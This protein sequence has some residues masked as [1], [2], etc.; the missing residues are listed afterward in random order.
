MRIFTPIRAILLLAALL[1]AHPLAAQTLRIGVRAAML[2]PDP[3][4]SFNPDRG[5]TLQVYE[6]LLLQDANLQPTPGLAVAWKMRDPTTWE[7]KLRPGVLFQDGTPL[8]PADVLFSMN[9]IREVDVTQNYRANLRE[10]TGAEAEGSD[11][12]VIH[13][14]N[15][16]PTLPFDLATFPIVSARA[17]EHAA[18]EDFNGGRAAVGTGPYRL[19]KW[20]P[21]QG[22]ILERNPK[23]WGKGPEWERV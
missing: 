9:R 4:S 23:Y 8:T 19:V 3:A 14:R 5:I 6:P 18:Q 1:L 22:V 21:G 12:V 20:T 17:A 2:T 15:P 11:T 16:A 10:V 7:L 13:T